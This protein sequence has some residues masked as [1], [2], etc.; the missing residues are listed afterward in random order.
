M[1]RIF[2]SLFALFISFGFAIDHAEAKRFGGGKSF[3]MQRSAPT[4]QTAAPTPQQQGAAPTAAPK[5]NSWMGPIAGLA[6]GLGLA[7]LFS[8]L[9][10]GEGMA[11]F[12][13][14]ALLALAAFMLFRWFMRRNAPATPAMQYAGMPQNSP[15]AFDQ[16]PAAF[17][18][19]YAASTGTFPPGFDADAF[20]REAKLNFIRLQA[21]FDA[22]NLDDVRAFTA[23]EV[24]AAISMQLAE[25]GD[26]PQ[27]TDVLMLNAEVLEAVDED[28]RHVV[29]VRFTGQV[30]E[31]AGAAPVALDEVWYLSKPINGQGGWVITGIQQQ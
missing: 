15:V 18:G 2:I 19:S 25:R 31:E 20:A 26:A 5:K 14:M 8:H 24:F 11:N 13:M 30:R 27:T 22:R 16:T 9:G 7:A 12:M 21:A 23:P 1:K 3:G 6:A 29:S 4:K 28:N 17:G 10:M